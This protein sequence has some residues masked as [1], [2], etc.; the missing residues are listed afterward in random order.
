[1]RLRNANRLRMF[2][3]Q[4]VEKIN[5]RANIARFKLG[6]RNSPQGYATHLPGPRLVRMP[7][8]L[9]TG[10]VVIPIEKG[11]IAAGKFEYTRGWVSAWA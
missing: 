11:V 6:T 4:L 10:R 1:M 3:D 5:R 9:D 7:G 2:A 8:D